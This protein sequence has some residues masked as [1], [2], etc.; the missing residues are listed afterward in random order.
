MAEIELDTTARAMPIAK[1]LQLWILT[2]STCSHLTPE[3]PQPR[4]TCLLNP[5]EPLP[6]ST[7]IFAWNH[8]Y[9]TSQV[10]AVCASGGIAQEHLGRQRCD[11]PR[12]GMGL[13]QRCSR[14]FAGLLLVSLVQFLDF[15]YTL[16]SL[17]PV[18]PLSRL[19]TTI[20]STTIAFTIAVC[21]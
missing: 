18:R 15:S 2:C 11:R 21:D 20:Q 3:K 8:S 7:R 14:T 17:S 10:L 4:I 1:T 9:I 6:P 5:T 19:P 13:Q 16:I 12:S